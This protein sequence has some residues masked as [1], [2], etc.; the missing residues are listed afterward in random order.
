MIIVLRLLLKPTTPTYTHSCQT[1]LVPICSHF[2]HKERLCYLIHLN[3]KIKEVLR[4]K[5]Y[6]KGKT[7]NTDF[8]ASDVL[9]KCIA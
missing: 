2:F 5:T 3:T 4:V 6:H 9:L 1:F 8:S 7:P